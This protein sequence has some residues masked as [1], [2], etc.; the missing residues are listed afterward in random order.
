MQLFTSEKFVAQEEFMRFKAKMISFAVLL[1]VIVSAQGLLAQRGRM[2][3]GHYDPKTEV[4]IK[5]TVEKLDQLQYTNMPGMGLH[6][7]VKTDKETIGVHLGPAAF[8]EKTMTFKE[9][10]TVEVVGSKVMMMGR[11]TLI[12]REVK[13]GDQV[14]K[15]RDE[16]GMPLWMRGPVETKPVS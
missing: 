14:L 1:V 15:L 5:G 2:R 9:G 7:I 11:P 10:D 3:M 4:T 16:R 6:L 8:I 12:A 13:K